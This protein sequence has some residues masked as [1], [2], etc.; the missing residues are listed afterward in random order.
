MNLWKTSAIKNL[1]KTTANEDN[2]SFK[3]HLKPQTTEK[4]NSKET[5]SDQNYSG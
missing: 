4:I 3:L 1:W 5:F 2:Y